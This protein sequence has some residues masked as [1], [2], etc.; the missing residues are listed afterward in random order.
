MEEDP[1]DK[2]P[3]NGNEY[4]R[5]CFVGVILGLLI[6]FFLIVIRMIYEATSINTN[7]I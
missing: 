6:A 7:I 2:D 5:G 1:L 3:F 4:N